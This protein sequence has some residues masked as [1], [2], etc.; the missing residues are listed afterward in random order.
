MGLYWQDQCTFTKVGDRANLS[1]LT[2]V[3]TLLGIHYNVPLIRFDYNVQR[4]LSSLAAFRL[5]GSSS[6]D[7]GQAMAPSYLLIHSDGILVASPTRAKFRLGAR[8]KNQLTGERAPQFVV[9]YLPLSIPEGDV[10][11]REKKKKDRLYCCGIHIWALLGMR[12]R[13]HCVNS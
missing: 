11:V 1:P 4:E 9:G 6:E 2:E 5:Y 13:V 10:V 8:Q 12:I 7:V 3:T